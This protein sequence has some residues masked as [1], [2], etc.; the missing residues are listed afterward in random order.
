L[1]KLYLFFTIAFF[2]IFYQ[3]SYSYSYRN[4]K[5]NR[6]AKVL[7]PGDEKRVKI[8]VIDTGIDF[9]EYTKPY[10]CK[11]AHYDL[12]E[13]GIHDKIRHG[14]NIAG[15][16]AKSMNPSK[17][18]L[19]IIKYHTWYGS[20]DRELEALRIIKEDN[21]IKFVNFSS[22]GPEFNKSEQDLIN[23]ILDKNIYFITSA[24]NDGNDLS[25]T[26]YYYP[27]CYNFNS[28]YF[29][30]VGNGLSVNGK[31]SS[32]NYNG[33]VKYWMNGMKQLGFGIVM[34]GTSQS[35]AN[36]TGKLVKEK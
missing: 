7:I 30:V 23:D 28:K 13:E 4:I 20:I 33:P 32:S 18:C 14:T 34:S 6:I 16:I 5:V 19:L 8:A 24:G 21:N 36:M 10:L 31:V 9:N 11:G 1:L 27:A 2:L 26:C 29:F 15:L 12:T 22:G 3:L 35:T 25:N 17:S